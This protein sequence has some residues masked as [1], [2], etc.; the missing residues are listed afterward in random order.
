MANTNRNAKTWALAGLLKRINL[1]E[2]PKLLR[3]EAS[4]LAKKIDLNDIAGAEQTLIDEGYSCR[5]VQQLSATFVLMGLDKR[6]H[7]NSG[8]RLSDDHI[9]RKIMVEHDLARCFLADLNNVAET[10][11]GLN[12]LTDVSSEFRN[13]ANILGHFRAMKEH[14]EREEDIIFPY[15]RK[16]GWEGLCRAAQTEHTKIRIDVD[17]LVMLTATFKKDRFEDFKT[18][19][20]TIVQRLS[21]IMLEHLSYEDELLWP[22]SLVVIDD[23]KVWESIK[24]LCDEIGYCG[25]R[26]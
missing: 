9:L 21:P 10:I 6:K 26:K 3:S 17:N 8:S 24:A 22:I 20:L 1:G 7:N 19:L 14:I 15:L 11:R 25:A 18:W 16:F 23:V 12:G 2:D 5:V 4:Q 13:L